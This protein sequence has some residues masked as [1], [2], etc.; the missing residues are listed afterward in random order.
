MTGLM[1]TLVTDSGTLCTK[2]PLVDGC[3]RRENVTGKRAS[4]ASFSQFISN[5]S[6]L[7]KF[8]LLEKLDFMT[9]PRTREISEWYCAGNCVT[10]RSISRDT[11]SYARLNTITLMQTQQTSMQYAITENLDLTQMTSSVDRG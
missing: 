4:S 11:S 9:C 10:L 5:F 2:L 8:P 1:K 3:K 7:L 6:K